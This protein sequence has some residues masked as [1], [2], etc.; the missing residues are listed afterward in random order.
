MRPSSEV[1]PGAGDVSATGGARSGPLLLWL[2]RRQVALA[3]LMLIIAQVAWRAQF[4]SHL[5]FFREDI[6]NLD[7]SKESQ[8]SWH[9]LTFI[10]TGHLMIG[11]RVIVWIVGRVSL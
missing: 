5:Y 9:Y 11:E 1:V 6:L 4:L 2:A 3:A 7:L 8:L 10:G